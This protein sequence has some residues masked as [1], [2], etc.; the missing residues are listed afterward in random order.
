MADPLDLDVRLD[1]FDLPIGTIRRGES[2]A[3]SFSYAESYLSDEDAVTLS[4]A[5]PATDRQYGDPETRAFF[6]NLLQER[7]RELQIIRDREGLALDDLAG[8]LLHL[9]KDCAGA[10]SVLPAGAPP[11]KVPGVPETDYLPLSD[12][13]LIEI[14]TSLHRRRRLPNDAAD[15]S[16]LAGVQS[17]IALT[18]LPDGR[19]A[20]PKP[21]SGAPTTHILKVPDTGH[22]GD[23]G[24]ENA[25]MQLCR[26][27]GLDTAET[28]VMEIGGVEVLRILRYDRGRDDAGRIVRIHQEDFAQALGLPPTLKYERDGRDGR[29]FDVGGVAR[30]LNATSRPAEERLTFIRST[31][32]DMF[33]GNVDGHAKNIALLHRPGGRCRLAPRYDV[34]PT[35][36][37]PNLTD[38]FAYRIGTAER[39]EDVNTQEFEAFLASLGIA[40]AAGRRRLRKAQAEDVADLIA[41][42]LAEVG[43]EYKAFADLIAANMRVLLPALGCGVPEAARDRDAF[44]RRGGGWTLS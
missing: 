13:R 31:L 3:L 26:A 23:A 37:D 15:P 28:D 38:Q 1:G 33:V 22:L 20:E 8:L 25:A 6:G 27:I 5:L 30:V 35:R 39:L 36:L 43:V 7:D 2:G 10:I 44:V 9:G 41:Q 40:T 17:K 18:V 24:I 16:P 19:F 34:T 14:V 29:R 12:A 21:G 4:L 32:F 42:H 11:V